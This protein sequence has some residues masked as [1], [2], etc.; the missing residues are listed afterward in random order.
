[1]SGNSDQV[2]FTLMSWAW[3]TPG[4]AAG[5]D[6]PAMLDAYGRPLIGRHHRGIDDCRN[7]LAVARA[8][9]E[10]DG[11]LTRRFPRPVAEGDDTT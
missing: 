2:D 10:A 11:D 5:A 3:S 1:M 9:I 6:L 7:I 8:T 4:V